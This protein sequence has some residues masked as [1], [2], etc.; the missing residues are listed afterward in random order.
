MNLIALLCAAAAAAAAQD[1]ALTRIG[2]AGAVK[3]AVSAVAPGAAVGRVLE[4]GKP[5]FLNDHV[6]TGAA[7]RL[8]VLLLDQTVFTM[9]PKSDLVLDEFVYDPATN[10]GKV[11]ASVTKGVF[12]F[13]TGKVA[14]K[15]PANMKVKLPAGTIGI[16][17]TIAAG[18]VSD[19]SSTVILLGPGARNNADE[20]PGEVAVSN[21]GGEVT[22]TQP[23]FGTTVAQGQPPAAVTDM[24]GQAVQILGALGEQPPQQTQAA[25]ETTEGG[26]AGGQAGQ[27]TAAGKVLAVAADDVSQ[28]SESL[29]TDTVN[30]A[31]EAAKAA[32]LAAGISKWDD[33]R[34]V[35]AGTAVYSVFQPQGGMCFGGICSSGAPIDVSATLLVDFGART[36][37]GEGQV[38]SDVSILNSGLGFSDSTMILPASFADL[39]GDAVIT[40]APGDIPNHTNS[41]FDNTTLTFRNR[42]GIA[43]KDL[44]VVVE[45]NDSLSSVSAAG[46]ATGSRP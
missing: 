13:V 4:S 1:T 20:N 45:Y 37:G 39:T 44:A 28:L 27:D 41:N 36:Y 26:S 2:A 34:S 8:Q 17:G 30:A 40:L 18:E 33:V 25:P 6:T 42:D 14:R 24:S 46:A 23:G 43:A 3:G 5:V 12:R 31:Q 9:G 16:R 11:A 19:Q 38:T 22:I 7:G 15:D 32:E 10:A 35:E 29:N 21:A